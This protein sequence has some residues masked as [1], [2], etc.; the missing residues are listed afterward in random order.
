MYL[1][2]GDDAIPFWS[3]IDTVLAET[4]RESSRSDSG[5]S[6]VDSGSEPKSPSFPTTSSSPS[7]GANDDSSPSGTLSSAFL[8]SKTD[9]DQ[10]SS[11]PGTL[12]AAFFGTKEDDVDT[13]YVESKQDDPAQCLSAKDDD[14]P[15]RTF[16]VLSDD[17]VSTSSSIF[18]SST[19]MY[20]CM[21]C[22]VCVGVCDV[23]VGAY[24][25]RCSRVFLFTTVLARV[26]F[27]SRKR[28]LLRTLVDEVL[29]MPW[30]GRVREGGHI[31]SQGQRG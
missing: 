6:P 12:S 20:V 30:L 31:G 26:E 5:A 14:E 25:L 22:S 11:P 9:G 28:N 15:S 13:V 19:A 17:S 4:G 21:V 10:R 29:L 23:C 1:C 16:S 18:S 24:L 2:L 3:F 8:G 7:F 27:E